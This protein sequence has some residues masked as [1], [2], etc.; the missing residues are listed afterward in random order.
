MFNTKKI[1]DIESR[2][3]IMESDINHIK[4]TLISIEKTLKYDIMATE[5]FRKEYKEAIAIV[6]S[7]RKAFG[8]QKDETCHGA[9][10]ETPQL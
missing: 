2:L 8:E 1:N 9:H 10:A 5:K 3:T 4:H 6:G 7:L